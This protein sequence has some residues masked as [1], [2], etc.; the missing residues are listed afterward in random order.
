MEMA[1]AA[2]LFGAITVWSV[3]MQRVTPWFALDV[4]DAD[5]Y[6]RMTRQFAAGLPFVQAAGPFVFRIATPWLASFA[7]PAQIEHGLPFYIINL[8]AAFVAAMLLLVWLRRFVDSPGVRVLLV[9]LWI[10][11]WHSPARFTFFDP[12]YVD[13]LFIVF[14]LAG[15]LLV[16][17]HAEHPR[18]SIAPVLALVAFIGTLCRES[19]VIVAVAFI[20]TAFEPGTARPRRWRDGAWAVAILLTTALA[21]WLTH[22]VGFPRGPYSPLSQPILMVRTKPLYTWVLGWFFA[23]GP[24]ILAMIAIDYA[25]TLAFLRSRPHLAVYLVACVLLSFFGGTDTERIAAWA[26]PVVY[27]LAGRAIEQFR[28]VLLRWPLVIVLAVVQLA[29]ERLLWPVPPLDYTIRPFSTID[30][31]WLQLREALNRMIVIDTHYGNL[32]SFFGS[33]AWHAVILAFDIVFVT[34]VVVLVRSF[35]RQ[36]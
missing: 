13:P 31:R 12:V 7:S 26:A 2:A 23:F 3:H 11:E 1:M 25:R 28:E 8:T 18:Y 30:S 36:P 19:M 6:L 15:L 10:A 20:A 21:V 27:V 24:A 17:L 14:M 22:A 32:W 29:S 5:E 9:T 35:D 4:G 34:A 16:D 33:R